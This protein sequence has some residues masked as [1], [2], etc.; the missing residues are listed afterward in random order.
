VITSNL[1]LLDYMFTG[2][3]RIL[4]RKKDR[5]KETEKARERKREENE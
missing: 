1:T 4:V 2:R 5:N 3:H